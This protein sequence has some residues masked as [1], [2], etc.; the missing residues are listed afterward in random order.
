MPSYLLDLNF[1]WLSEYIERN[2]ETFHE[3]KFGLQTV[4]YL[5]F[6]KNNIESILVSNILST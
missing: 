1:D 6:H 3:N 2:L 5:S 4:F